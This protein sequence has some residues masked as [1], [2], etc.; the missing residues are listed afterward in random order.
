MESKVDWSKSPIS[1][2]GL[3]RILFRAELQAK[4]VWSLLSYDWLSL[5]I[6]EISIWTTLDK[7]IIVIEFKSLVFK[8]VVNLPMRNVFEEQKFQIFSNF[9]TN[10]IVLT[11]KITG[12]KRL[13]VKGNL[14]A[15]SNLISALPLDFSEPA[16]SS[17]SLLLFEFGALKPS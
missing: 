12:Q 1:R 4:G 3:M 5:F 7:T 15:F 2:K 11:K 17:E 9:S 16:L 8:A 10:Q 13:I 14:F 6:C